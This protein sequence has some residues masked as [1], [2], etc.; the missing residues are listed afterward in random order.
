MLTDLKS[1]APFTRAVMVCVDAGAV[2]AHALQVCFLSPSRTYAINPG[3]L[4]ESIIPR[5][6]ACRSDIWDHGASA[7]HAGAF[8]CQM[9]FV[10]RARTFFHG[11]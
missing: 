5:F 3:L 7:A 6:R 8:L 2:H 11:V 1:T 10:R 9:K 4:P